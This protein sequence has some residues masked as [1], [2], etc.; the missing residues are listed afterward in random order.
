MANE[1]ISHD[2]PSKYKVLRL[3]KI[4]AD[5]KKKVIELEVQQIPNTPPEVLES[6]RDTAIQDAKRILEI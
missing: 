3:G 2:M 6:Q 5:F 4:V 1:E